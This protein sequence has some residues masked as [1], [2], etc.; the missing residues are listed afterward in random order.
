MSSETDE[1]VYEN[2]PTKN[3]GGLN[4]IDYDAMTEEEMKEYLEEWDRLC[5]VMKERTKELMK[6]D[7]ETMNTIIYA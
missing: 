1:D 7:E 6:V 3:I 5:D 2:P 4:V